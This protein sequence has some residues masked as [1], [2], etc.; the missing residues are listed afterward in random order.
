[1]SNS[2]SLT[3]ITYYTPGVKLYAAVSPVAIVRFM[4][5]VYRKLRDEESMRR[6]AHPAPIKNSQMAGKKL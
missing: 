3:A 5:V 2:Y 6:N 4:L 1:M